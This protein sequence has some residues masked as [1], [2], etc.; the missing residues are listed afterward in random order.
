MAASRWLKKADLQHHLWSPAVC[1]PALCCQRISGIIGQF[2]SERKIGMSTR[3]IAHDTRPID[4]RTGKPIGSLVQPGYY[5]G[6]RTLSQQKF[7]DTKTREVVL[8]RVNNVPPIR[9]FSREEARLL[10]AVCDH[11]LPQDDRDEAHRIPIVPQIDKRLFNDSHDG[12]RYEDMPPDR[13][14][15][16]LGIKAIDEIAHHLHGCSFLE[17]GPLEQDQIL[18]S[19]H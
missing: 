15:Y 8:D 5:P 3:T 17:I 13:E 11:V 10:E 4:L 2:A 12:Y 1:A 6:Y 7:W 18:K 9:F 19:I 16:R 14:A